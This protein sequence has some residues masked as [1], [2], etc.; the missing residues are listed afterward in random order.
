MFLRTR[1]NKNVLFLGH[2]ARNRPRILEEMVCKRVF[3]WLFTISQFTVM[4]LL[5]SRYANTVNIKPIPM[6]AILTSFLHNHPRAKPTRPP[7]TI[8]RPWGI[9]E[10]RAVVVWSTTIF[11]Q[12]FLRSLTPRTLTTIIVNIIRV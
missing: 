11:H 5:Y 4:D 10:L 2:K 8:G 3:V 7:L 1:R 12:S 6:I 9:R